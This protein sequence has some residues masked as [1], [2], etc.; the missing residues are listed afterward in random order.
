MRAVRPI[1]AVLLALAPRAIAAAPPRTA[2]VQYATA[3][4]GYLDA[5][6]RAGLT[7]GTVLQVRRGNRV[8]ATC[9][10]EHVSPAHAECVGSMKAG[11]T[12]LLPA[13][14]EAAAP[15]SRPAPPIS[16]AALDRERAVL[17]AAAFEKVE[18]R[19]AT[20]VATARRTVEVSIGYNGFF[21]TGAGPWQRERADVTMRG[22]PL[23]GGF[24]LDVDMSAQRWSRRSDPVSFRPGDPTQLY[25]WEA[26][27]SRRPASGASL[28]L[29]R[30]RPWW[31]PG[32][33]I[34]DGAQAGWRT[35]GGTETGVFGGVVP[36]TITLAPSLQHGTFGA[37]WAGQYPG[38][39]DS[40]LRYFRHE[41]R[42]A[43]VNTDELGKRIEGEAL[44][45]AR[46]LRV[47]DAG[48]DA[49]FA[50]GDQEAPG[51]LDAIRVNGTLRPVESFDVSG[52]FRYEGLPVPELDGPGNVM[53]GGT[54]RHAEVSASWQPIT[55]LRISAVSGLSTDLT[56]DVTRRWIGPEIAF[57]RLIG[58]RLGASVGYFQEDGWS[59]GR[60]AWVQLIGRQR[61]IGQ[62]LL[63][64]SWFRTR[65]VAPVELDELAAALNVQAQIWKYAALRIGAYGRTT[66]NGQQ[67]PFAPGTG[68]SGVLDASLVGTF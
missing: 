55:L 53:T 31:T 37:Y 42:V 23:G 11:D 25:V 21:A 14:P 7:A 61:G 4:R 24:T 54:A 60:S 38:G 66:L 18:Y 59:P 39:P 26:A 3:T 43:F 62:V 49:K 16:A 10:V 41:A 64:V 57:P 34:F 45:E 15:V 27:I 19:E 68:Q 28:S 17:S 56:T 52:S 12:V 46:I 51:H 47:L 2:N 30:V 50:K 8:V 65:D 44:V 35:E 9:K 67:S 48:V 40:V 1:T 63:R 32:Q 29:G 22:A 6:A 5:G 36:D 58:E 20:G 33:A 13:A